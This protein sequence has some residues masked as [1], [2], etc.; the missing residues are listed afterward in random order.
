MSAARQTTTRHIQSINLVNRL[1]FGIF[2]VKMR[3]HV[4]VIVHIND[5]SKKFAY[6]WH[7]YLKYYTVGTYEKSNPSNAQRA[8]FS[9]PTIAFVSSSCTS[10]HSFP[11]STTTHRL[12]SCLTISKY[13]ARTR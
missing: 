7:I 13:P 5:N 11:A 2:S 1:M 8:M 9:L 6:A 4:V 12:G 3:R 10:F